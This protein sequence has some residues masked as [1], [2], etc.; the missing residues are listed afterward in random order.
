MTK[1]KPK[2][3]LTAPEGF[4]VHLQGWCYLGKIGDLISADQMEKYATVKVVLDSRK[5][6]VNFDSIDYDLERQELHYDYDQHYWSESDSKVSIR[7]YEGHIIGSTSDDNKELLLQSCCG[8]IW[9]YRSLPLIILTSILSSTNP[10]KK[11]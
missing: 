9:N 4:K 10:I 2:K 11:K 5:L 1:Q 6:T 7:F 3:K 8:S